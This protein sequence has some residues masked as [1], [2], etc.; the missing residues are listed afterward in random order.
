MTWELVTPMSLEL[1]VEATP[2]FVK[3]VAAEMEGAKLALV[4]HQ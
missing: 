2:G 1:A 3:E 4:M